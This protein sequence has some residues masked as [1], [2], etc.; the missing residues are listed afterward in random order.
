MISVEQSGMEH[1]VLFII[2]AE[3]I[4]DLFLVTM[5]YSMYNT[6]MYCLSHG[7]K[8]DFSKGFTFK[9]MV[10]NIVAI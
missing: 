7:M 8:Y 2:K 6:Y 1:S 3:H 9:F 4:F 5:V 10:L